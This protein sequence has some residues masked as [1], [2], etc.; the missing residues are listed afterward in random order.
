[1]VLVFNDL[2]IVIDIVI[3]IL[4]IGI[5]LVVFELFDCEFIKF[6]EFFLNKKFIL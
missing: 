1:M 6:S 5:L 3:E 2:F 4:K